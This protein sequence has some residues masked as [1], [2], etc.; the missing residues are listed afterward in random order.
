MTCRT[1]QVLCSSFLT[2]LT[3]YNI[4]SQIRRFRQQ[5]IPVRNIFFYCLF[6][7]KVVKKIVFYTT[8]ICL[9]F[10]E[11]KWI[12]CLIAA[13]LHLCLQS[14]VDAGEYVLYQMK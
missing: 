1:P 13:G 8:G 14:H 7:R 2:N 6:E 11:M 12:L 9:S 5:Y 10:S 4:S 3:S